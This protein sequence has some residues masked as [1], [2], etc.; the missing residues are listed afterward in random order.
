VCISDRWT[1]K[2][3]SGFK[4][5]KDRQ[6]AGKKWS[7]PIQIDI[8]AGYQSRAERRASLEFPSRYKNL[9]QELIKL[10]VGG[11]SDGFTVYANAVLKA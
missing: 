2:F 5:S 4:F 8:T 11:G 10:R 3:V 9:H 7:L 1:E 6:I